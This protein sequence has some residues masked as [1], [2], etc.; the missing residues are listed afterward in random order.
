MLDEGY[1]QALLED[2]ESETDAPGRRPPMDKGVDS[3]DLLQTPRMAR[4]WGASPLP[5]PDDT[6]DWEHADVVLNSGESFPAIISGYNRGGLL[7]DFGHIQAFLPASHL[8]CPPQVV[9]GDERMAALAAR[10]G[11]T[12]TV[13]VAEIERDRRR[14]ILSER[15]VGANGRAAEILLALKPGQICS[16]QVTNLCHFGAFID[17][18]GFEGLIHISELSWGR[19]GTPDEVLRPGDAVEALVLEVNPCEQKVALSIKRLRPDPWQGVEARYAPGQLVEA[20][21]TNVVNFGAFARLEEGME[22]LIHISELA[23]G[24]FMHPRNVIREGDRVR[25]RVMQVDPGKRRIAL[26]LRNNDGAGRLQAEIV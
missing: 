18:G 5:L 1:W 7:A 19:V 8:L 2:V 11:D 21:V 9:E 16:G 15:L 3:P 26:T 24:S 22:G 4:R 25:A 20:L 23:E 6:A 12:L 14:L 10:V 17:L 13:R